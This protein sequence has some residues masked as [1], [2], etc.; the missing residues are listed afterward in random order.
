MITKD[1]NGISVGHGNLC[2]EWRATAVL[3]AANLTK[4]KKYYFEFALKTVGDIKLGF[5][6][7]QFNVE[8][9]LAVGTDNHSW[10]CNLYEME[11]TVQIQLCL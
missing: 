9:S 6:D 7:S 5:A 1:I 3:K 10:S 4:G 8:R 2:R 11:K